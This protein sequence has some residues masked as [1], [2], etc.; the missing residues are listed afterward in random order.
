MIVLDTNV[1]S[2]LM[3]PLP[4]PAVEAW[5]AD[6]A[7][8]NLFLSAVSE[9]EL[10]YGIAIMP[11][12]QRRHA[13]ETEVEAMLREVFACRVLPFDSDAARAYAGIAASCRASGRPVSQSDGQIAAIAHSRGMAVATRN[14]RHFE[15]MAVDIIDPWANT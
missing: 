14:I 15:G 4:N 12:G 8:T 10:L 13:L 11:V 7:A 9:A 6:R 1:V 2:E 3:R 5:V